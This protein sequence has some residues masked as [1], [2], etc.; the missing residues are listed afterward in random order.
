MLRKIREFKYFEPHTLAEAL[1]LLE[2]YSNNENAKILAGGTDL[3]VGMKE[4][5]LTP[6]YL[7]NIKYIPGLNYIKQDEEKLRIGATT[8]IGEIVDNDLINKKFNILAQ[9]ASVL[10]S[11]QVR[12]RATIGGNLCNAAPS[13]EM[14]PA[15]LTLD[16]QARIA[17]KKGERI[18]PLEKFFLGP[19]KTVLKKEILVEIIVP[20]FPPQTKGI[21][22]KNSPRKAMDIAAV[23]VAVA[24]VL[25]RDKKVFNKVRIALGAVAPTPMRAVK[26]EEFLINKE[27]SS[28]AIREA[29]QIAS[30]EAK[31]ITD[32]RSSEWYRREIVRVSVERAL[33]CV[34]GYKNTRLE[35]GEML[36][37]S[38]N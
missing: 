34:T 18:V 29:A 15:L 7:I 4:K 24:A 25:D 14:A 13:A 10:G 23:G 19:G 3:L 1:A 33:E 5:G 22:I 17:G 6:D 38:V 28:S 9:A 8:T 37:E 2:Q 20:F 31:P 12:N 30:R 32:I 16:A 35:R 36:N 27:I 26:A 11:V 21:Y